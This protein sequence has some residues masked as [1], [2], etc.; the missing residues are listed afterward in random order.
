[1]VA[2]AIPKEMS[3]SDIWAKA[4]QQGRKSLARKG[5]VNTEA[6]EWEPWIEGPKDAREDMDYYVMHGFTA[7][8]SA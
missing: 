2:I 1:M 7:D 4:T 8:A 6:C 3:R 5:V